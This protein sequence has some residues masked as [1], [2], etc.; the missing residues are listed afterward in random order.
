MQTFDQDRAIAAYIDRHALHDAEALPFTAL[1]F[2]QLVVMLRY[3]QAH[4]NVHPQHYPVPSAAGLL[5]AVDTM[6]LYI[7]HAL[8]DLTCWCGDCEALRIVT[9][10]ELGTAMGA[11]K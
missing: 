6:A 5:F 1:P 9:D 10:A 11:R 8:N 7:N 3:L 2:R 4:L